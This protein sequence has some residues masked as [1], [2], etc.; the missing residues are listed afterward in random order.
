[1]G[2]P[3]PL[4]SRRCPLPSPKVTESSITTIYL[5]LAHLQELVQLETLEARPPHQAPEM[6][7][8]IERVRI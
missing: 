7:K 2:R 6:F 3:A 1:M 8:G 4:K 5:P